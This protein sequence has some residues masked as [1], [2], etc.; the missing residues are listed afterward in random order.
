[1]V[2]RI[3]KTRTTI[4]AAMLIA[5]VFAAPAASAAQVTLNETMTLSDGTPLATS[6]L[7]PDASG[8]PWPTVLVR[9]P[10]DY[11]DLES[12]F[13][14]LTAFGYA[15]VLQYTRGCGKSGGDPQAFRTDKEDG[16]ETLDWVL[17]QPWCDGRVAMGGAS[18]LAIP[19]YL[20]APGANEGL[21]CQLLAIATADVYTYT[22][23]NGGAFR[24]ADVEAWLSWVGASSWL[25]N[26]ESHRA[27]DS[28]WDPVR[29]LPSQAA[30]I[31]SA[32]IH[33]GGWYD[34]FTQATLDGYR[35]WRTA[36]DPAIRDRQRL[37]M[38]PFDHYNSGGRVAGPRTFPPNASM[39]IVA[40]TLSFL[41]WCFDGYNDVIDAWPQV[42]Y[43]LMGA[44]EPDAPGNLWRA[45]DDWP[46]PADETRLYLAA[47]G[48]LSPLPPG[49]DGAEDVGLDP[50]N[51]SPTAG[52]RNLVGESGP[53]DQSGVESRADSQVYTSTP[54]D[55]PLEVVGRLSATLR[56]A[57]SATDADVV[58]RVSDVYPDGRSLLLTDGIQRLSFRTGCEAPQAV[59]PGEPV[60]VTVDL[61]STAYVFPA[62]HRVRVNVT[63]ASYPRFE[64]NPV[65]KERS[66]GTA[67]QLRMP[68]AG[69]SWLSLPVPRPVEPPADEVEAADEAVP[70]T[71]DATAGDVPDAGPDAAADTTTADAFD[72]GP[73]E[74]P[75]DVLA[76]DPA[77][78][79]PGDTTTADDGIAGDVPATDL[80]P[81]D[82]IAGDSDPGPSPDLA[83]PD[84]AGDDVPVT[85]RNGGGCAAGGSA[86]AGAA[87]MPL[88]LAFAALAWNRRSVRKSRAGSRDRG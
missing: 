75:A 54:L 67:F 46:V 49:A 34:V 71:V 64:V 78:D 44:D 69:T 66:A 2:P 26:L 52:G 15:F 47:G 41:Q 86:P 85:H 7:L 13:G 73:D 30:G 80:P 42:Q 56:V 40:T 53:V 37:V 20:M 58:V 61:W 25:Q 8:G 21:Q 60:D 87:G 81:R 68:V 76:D 50:A 82:G 84:G 72:A 57:P 14:M 55:A 39:D 83:S 59:T 17:A 62:G 48:G 24:Q 23:F 28:W 6:V 63:A 27:C 29:V 43:Y 31:R 9:S 32:A 65:L 5:A 22:A 51:P 19:A 3:P 36:P 18:A 88:L 35:L 33:F 12:Q 74:V 11:P 38:G 45:A 10:Y 1:M 4:A 70:D 77:P 79:L 16:H